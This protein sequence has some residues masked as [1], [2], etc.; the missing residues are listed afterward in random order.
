MST[1]AMATTASTI[2][3]QMKKFIDDEKQNFQQIS[4]NFTARHFQFPTKSQR[5]IDVVQLMSEYEGNF[6]TA[7][8]YIRFLLGRASKF[9]RLID[10]IGT[11]PSAYELNRLTCL[12][13]YN[14]FIQ[15]Y[16][17]IMSAIQTHENTC[18][19]SFRRSVERMIPTIAH[20][21]INLHLQQLLV[22]EGDDKY[23]YNTVT[24]GA[25]AVHH[26][27]FTNGGL[28]RIK[29]NII[30]TNARLKSLQDN[31]QD[32]LILNS[33]ID[34]ALDHLCQIIESPSTSVEH[35]VL[36]MSLQ[37]VVAAVLSLLNYS[38][39]DLSQIQTHVE[40]SGLINRSPIVKEMT[41]P[42]TT[43][44]DLIQNMKSIQTKAEKLLQQV[45]SS[46]KEAKAFD[47]EQLENLK[48]VANELE[49]STLKLILR[50]IF[51]EGSEIESY[52]QAYRERF[53]IAFSQ[54]LICL[55]FSMYVLLSS[56]KISE[57][58][59]NL[60]VKH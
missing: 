60:Y 53:D 50:Q 6:L 38:T 41:D 26:S 37:R 49:K 35:N 40:G 30:V 7:I 43:A 17:D 10:E 58:S 23:I 57:Q 39:V 21:P 4:T 1:G 42:E 59:W 2:P 32:V 8:C 20:V 33:D 19:R 11:L 14:D 44:N 46:S 34:D 22:M 15:R 52:P 16:S 18:G 3:D 48:S 36:Q 24:L 56:V 28:S 31:F 45:K 55:I 27:Q 9:I 47:R 13:T 5:K 51:T 25:P 12:A 54:S 29:S